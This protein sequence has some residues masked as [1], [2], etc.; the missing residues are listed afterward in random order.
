MRYKND[1]IL[2]SNIVEKGNKTEMEETKMIKILDILSNLLKTDNLY[3]AREYLQIEI[4]N[5]TGET[6]EKCKNTKYYFYDCFCK[7]CSNT[8]C[9]SNRNKEIV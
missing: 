1:T 3:E 9:G 4:N 2:M 5:L 7:Y 6:E 8:N